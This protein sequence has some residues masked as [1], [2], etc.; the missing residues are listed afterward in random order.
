MNK[1][2][3]MFKYLY[4]NLSYIWIKFHMLAGL[5]DV[6]SVQHQKV[7]VYNVHIKTVEHHSM[8]VLEMTVIVYMEKY[9]I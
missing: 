7:L 3:V 8:Y 1:V 5:F 6:L 9:S 4:R 2:R